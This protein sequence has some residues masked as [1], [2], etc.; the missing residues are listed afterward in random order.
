MLNIILRKFYLSVNRIL[1]ALSRGDCVRLCN[2]Y[3]A[4]YPDTTLEL[5]LRKYF[6]DEFLYACLDLT[7]EIGYI[8][9]FYLDTDG[10]RSVGF[11]EIRVRD[12]GEKASMKFSAQYDA[13]YYRKKS[14]FTEDQKCCV[15]SE[16][17]PTPTRTL[18]G[19]TNM[20][21]S[22]ASGHT[23]SKSYTGQSEVWFT[24]DSSATTTNNNI[25]NV[26]TTNSNDNSV[27]INLKSY[28]SNMKIIEE[29]N[30]DE[31]ELTSKLSRL[32]SEMQVITEEFQQGKEALRRSKTE[33]FALKRNAAELEM[34]VRILRAKCISLQTILSKRDCN[35]LYRI[36]NNVLKQKEHRDR[37]D[38]LTSAH[39]TAMHTDSVKEID[40]NEEIKYHRHSSVAASG[41]N[42][43]INKSRNTV[44]R[45]TSNISLLTGVNMSA[46]EIDRLCVRLICSRTRMQITDMEYHMKNI[47]QLSLVRTVCSYVG[48]MLL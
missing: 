7:S 32:G 29:H 36:Y 31:K 34:W 10:D 19:Y 15:S 40:F 11:H 39:H 23:L 35:D 48:D 41:D 33:L 12:M 17:V 45:R 4:M 1:G 16:P 28:T 43:N 44:S 22:M 6:Q 46:D 27:T 25:S 30:E 21:T 3:N 8:D 18:S 37:D 42:S 14:V 26:T 2:R 47:H 13:D 5:S 24:Q 20:N 38:G 9:N